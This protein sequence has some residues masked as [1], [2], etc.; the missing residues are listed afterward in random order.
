MST[1]KT[2]V[3]RGLSALFVV[4]LITAAALTRSHWTPWVGRM[5]GLSVEQGDSESVHDGHEGHDHGDEPSPGEQEADAH[6]GH[7]HE[8][9]PAPHEHDEATALRLSPQAEANLGVDLWTVELKPF[10]RSISVPAMV[11]SRPGK[12]RT[13]IT[14]TFTGLVTRILCQEGEA[15]SPGTPLFELRL[16]HEE[17][18]GAQANLLETVEKLDVVRA[19]VARLA[20]VEAIGAL[21]GKDLLAQKYEEQKLEAVLRSQR[22]RL[23]LH[24]LQEDQID[25]I[26][27]TR[28]LLG[29]MTIVA[30]QSP[31]DQSSEPLLLVHELAVDLGQYVTAGETLAVLADHA[32]LYLEGRAFETDIAVLS[33]A[34]DDGRGLA[35]VFDS[36]ND[37][38]EVVEELELL[39][40]AG[41]VEADSRTL[42]FYVGLPNRI[43]RDTVRDDGRRFVYWHFKPGQRARLRVPVEAAVDRIVL[44]AQAV[45]ED[46][47]ETYVFEYN[48]DHFDRRSVHVEYR[49][50]DYVVL[51]N[52]GSVALGAKVTVRGAYQVHLATKNKGGQVLD[53]HAG[54]DH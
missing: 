26:I 5:V 33:R 50:Q 6:A 32:E 31:D 18:V 10:A 43:T 35:A 12:S 22:Q 15:V 24:Q 44:P 27:A 20:E 28:T 53:P 46:G 36:L 13:R 42:D 29:R 2:I 17:L 54:H 37:E 41:E 47:A 23:L 51:A 49:D 19:E 3:L 30:P 52:D 38:P 45:I 14:A 39:Y 8:N 16:T 40:L 11:V 1:K 48:V 34:A 21:A 9:E 4:L 25:E 7:D